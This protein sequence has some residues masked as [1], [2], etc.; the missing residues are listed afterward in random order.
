MVLF[1][2][3]YLKLINKTGYYILTNINEGT[4]IQVTN[5]HVGHQ[6]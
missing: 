2:G 4:P 5:E 6:R 3:Q 1:S